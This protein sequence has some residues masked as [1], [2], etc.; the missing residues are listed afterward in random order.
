[1]SGGTAV[2]ESSDGKV[3][4]VDT[5]IGEASAGEYVEV[6]GQVVDGTTMREREHTQFSEPIDLEN[7]GHFCRISTGSMRALFVK[8]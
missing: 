3:T 7:Y 6:V 5:M 4:I 8:D 1:M 2:V